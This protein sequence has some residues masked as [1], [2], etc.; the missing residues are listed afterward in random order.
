MSGINQFAKISPFVDDEGYLLQMNPNG[1][2]YLD[3]ENMPSKYEITINGESS[4]V[5]LKNGEL[6]IVYNNQHVVTVY[7]G[8]LVDLTTGKSTGTLIVEQD[9]SGKYSIIIID[10]NNKKYNV[11][12]NL[13]Y[14]AY[15]C[16]SNDS[17]EYSDTYI[18]SLPY[19]VMRV[20]LRI[21]SDLLYN[22]GDKFIGVIKLCDEK[23]NHIASFKIDGDIGNSKLEVFE[24][25]TVFTTHFGKIQ[26]NFIDANGNKIDASNVQISNIEFCIEYIVQ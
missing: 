9:T 8:N 13:L 6:G 4:N 17:L 14:A 12:D 26:V 15:F 22:N 1:T 20:T 21:T 3:K 11:T 16:P 10:E 24:C 5:K 19:R 2:V 25:Q 23:S 7:E 18:G